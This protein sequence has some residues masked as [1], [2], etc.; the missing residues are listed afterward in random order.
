V[1]Q[2]RFQWLLLISAVPLSKRWLINKM[3]ISE[4]GDDGRLMELAQG[5]IPMAGF[6]ISN[7]QPSAS[8][9]VVE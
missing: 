3:Y 8:V 7:V 4:T 9:S 6:V 1:V 5:S 2:D